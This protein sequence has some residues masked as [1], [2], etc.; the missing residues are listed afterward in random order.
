MARKIMKE[1]WYTFDSVNRT[2]TFPHY[3]PHEHLILITDITAN[4][5]IYN[6]SDPS[7]G[8][9]DFNTGVGTDGN[10]YTT[11]V[12]KYN[13]SALSD[14]DEIQVTLD[15]YEEQ[16]VPSEEMQDAVGKLKTSNPQ[17]LIDTDFEYGPQTSKWESVSTINNRPTSFGYNYQNMN[18]SNIATSTAGTR[19]ITVSLNTSTAT[20]TAVAGNASTYLATY[21]TNAAHGF[22]IGQYVTVTGASVAGYNVTGALIVAIP[23]A[24][25]FQV[26]NLTTAAAT[27]TTPTCTAG[28]VPPVGTPI[29][30]IDT[31]TLNSNGRY[32]IETRATESSFTYTA[33][34]PTSSTFASGSI[35]DTNRTLV[36]QESFYSNSQIGSAPTITS[37]SSLTTT[38]A[39]T[40][41]VV[42]TTTI[43]HGLSIGNE[44]AM[45][46]VTGL[47]SLNGNYAV[48]SIASPTQ[49]VYYV[50]AG[51]TGTVNAATTVTGVASSASSGVI[52][53]NIFTVTSTS[54]ISI[55]Q[56]VSG[57][58]IP[59]GAYVINLTV[60]ATTTIVTINQPLTGAVTA[61]SYIFGSSVYMR[62]QG[63]VQHR[64]FD[65]GIL[66]QTNAGSNN[67]SLIRQTRR[68]F[69]YQSGKSITMSSGTI[70]KPTLNIDS[71]TSTGTTIGSTVTVVLKEKH[72]FQP[73]YQI[74]IS[75]ST[76]AGYN[77]TYAV[78]NVI[79]FNSFTFV[80]TAVLNSTSAYGPAYTSTINWNGAVT[81]LGIYDQ[82]NGA[83]FEY[84]GQNLY[85]VRRY[86]TFQL[87]GR[88]T[89]TQGS[90]TVTGSTAFP[91]LFNKEIVPGDWIVIRGQSYQVQD[92]SSD[93]ALVLSS[94]YRGISASNV[95]VTKTQEQKIIQSEFT[96]DRLD[97]AGP[98]GYNLDLS[99]MQ[100]FFIDYSWY[101]AGSIR[102]GF[103]GAK[104]K[105]IWVNRMPNNNNNTMA[106]ARS[107]NLPARYESS[108]IPARTTITSQ[109]GNTDTI[110]NVASTSN[111]PNAGSLLVRPGGASNLTGQ[112]YEFLNYTSKTA[113]TFNGVIRVQP[114]NAAVTLS[115]GAAGSN[116]VTASS[117]NGLQIGQRII[118]SSFPEG[119]FIVNINGLVLTLSQGAVT[120]PTGTAIFPPLAYTTASTGTVST[121]GNAYAYSATS[122]VVLEHAYPT[123]GPGLS[124]WGTSVI[125]DGRFD[126][127]KSLV[128]NYGQTQSTTL[129][130]NNGTTGVGTASTSAT[131]TLATSN[132][133]IIAGMLVSGTG[134]PDGTYVTT[135]TSGTSI[136][137][138]NS[139]TL[140][141]TTLTFYGGNT[142]ALFSIRISPSVDNGVTGP[143]GQRELI[144][145]MQLI[146]KNLDISL[147][148]TTT[149]NVL[150]QAFLNGIPV[151][152]P[153]ATSTLTNIAWTNSIRNAIN[154]PNSS[155]AQ[156][157][158]YAGNNVTLFGGEG[159]GGF[160]VSSTGTSDISSVRDL[161][162]SIFGGGYGYSNSGIYPDGP[163][164]LTIVVTNL[165]ATPQAVLGRISWTE[166]QA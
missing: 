34:A 62:P 125:M 69:R 8:Y 108:T 40:Q 3:V 154:V 156:I 17:A 79:S 55:G 132:T 152:N 41:G 95:I 53:S 10:D 105:I 166:A 131:V 87:S 160:F 78:A 122:P 24:T 32:V 148:G 89:V 165:A 96:I 117:V 66:F 149:G 116:I 43:P 114:G 102:W 39:G 129:S 104:G 51:V 33:K 162:N 101:G 46:G 99:K 130:P 120:N 151:V 48:T 15:E 65:G 16:I 23:S 74:K 9:T 158:D 73:G 109:I 11:I 1:T 38:F 124:H 37:L 86:S 100:M 83:Y 136:T 6:F 144:N 159:T 157:A 146:L 56:T 119:T 112:F 164:T 28:V 94:S 111:F 140:S 81:R 42:V 135:V 103:R 113:T 36:I 72:N 4:K 82:Q 92:I 14:D 58:G 138:N 91:A 7:L 145:R 161:G 80:N 106:W 2:I 52:G 75:G 142:K 155:F 29:N 70:L 115:S 18:V 127:D 150:V 47:T 143:L 19:T 25:T 88:V 93:T 133:N 57:V 90:T 12:L 54:G 147:I 67:Q 126:D 77:G 123:Y 26:Q 60:G 118:H 153:G 27:L 35:L 163:D 97:G 139:V 59:T 5:V 98:S 44:I 22:S 30:V 110:I 20:L 31:L 49:F 134:V 50:P 64:A 141:S 84:D 137:L 61:T 121:T 68:Y 107:A 45:V 21:T 76:D 63:Q 13:T 71:M 128:F 85:V